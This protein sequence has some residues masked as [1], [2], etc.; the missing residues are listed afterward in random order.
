MK[1]QELKES[2]KIVTTNKLEK[3]PN[4][5]IN[6]ALIVEGKLTWLPWLGDNYLTSKTKTLIVGESHYY[7]PVSKNDIS[8]I[9][10]TTNDFTQ[11]VVN[12]IAIK[13]KLEDKR[14]ATMY[15]N[16]YRSIREL[17]QSREEYW[18]SVAFYNFI[19]QP[20]HSIKQRPNQEMIAKA[21]SSFKSVV[22]IL[23]PDVVIFIGVKCCEGYNDFAKD[24]HS[25]LKVDTKI[26]NKQI[27]RSASV[28][29]NSKEVPIHFI[30]HS[31]SFYSGDKW[32]KYFVAKNI[33]QTP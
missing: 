27:P 8:F 9:K 4:E 33:I 28:L 17:G 29:V 21:W 6:E 25:P 14:S 22:D 5:P 32:R 24:K 12:E 26:S 10:H 2:L 19:Q 20:M 30:K 18:N 3:Q 1:T 11:I 7:K 23:Q 15:E 13:R 16:F 31:S